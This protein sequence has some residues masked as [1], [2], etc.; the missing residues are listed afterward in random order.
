MFGADVGIGV[1]PLALE[2]AD[3][4]VVAGT[5][6]MGF[7]TNRRTSSTSG[8]YP[9]RRLRIRGRAVTHAL[10]GMVRF[11]QGLPLQA[12]TQRR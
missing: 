5:C 7:A 10:L 11:V 1:S 2:S 4:S 9:T 6:F 12:A 3:G 8:H